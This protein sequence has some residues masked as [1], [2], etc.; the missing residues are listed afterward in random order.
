MLGNTACRMAFLFN[1]VEGDLLHVDKLIFHFWA[2]KTEIISVALR[3]EHWYV[4]EKE[5]GLNPN[6]CREGANWWHSCTVSLW[7]NAVAGIPW[8]TVGNIWCLKD[9]AY[10]SGRSLI[11][12]SAY[13]NVLLKNQVSHLYFYCSGSHKMDS[14]LPYLMQHTLATAN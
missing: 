4:G 1:C 2:L 3:V 9:G 6:A 10:L 13:F 8:N 5:V 14:Q 11:S 7:S 12:Y